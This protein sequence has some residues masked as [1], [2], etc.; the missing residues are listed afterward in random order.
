[1]EIN[2]TLQNI[3]REVFKDPELLIHPE[4]T[5]NEVDNWDS[6]THLVMISQV[7]ETFGIRLKLKE[8]IKLKNVGD[9]I[10]LLNEKKSA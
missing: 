10:Q 6:I 9:L 3:F 8:L 5:A 7:E 1:M 2:E 4:M